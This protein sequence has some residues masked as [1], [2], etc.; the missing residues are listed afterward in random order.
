MLIIR[1]L[2]AALIL[3]GAPLMTLAQSAQVPVEVWADSLQ[4]RDLDMSPNAQR[5]AMLMR[6]ERGADHDLIVFDTDDI[7]G[8]LQAIQPEGLITT[9]LSWANDNFLIVNFVFEDESKG[10]PVYL[11]RTASYNVRTGEWT[12]LVRTKMRAD[13]RTGDRLMNRLG[14]GQVVSVLPDEPDYVL[15]A[16]NEERGKP[17]NYYK[18]NLENGQRSLVL[19][20][21]T[22]M[23]N[24][25]W[26]REGNARGAAEFDEGDVAIVSLA[27]VS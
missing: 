22:R 14:I 7:Q 2:L 1:A 23:A 13:I 16:H 27:R 4:V 19:K 9:G 26:D 24:Y 21:N 25:V 18:V 15:V 10:R 17:P 11:S 5:M 6:R 12:S 3:C 8:S 20:A